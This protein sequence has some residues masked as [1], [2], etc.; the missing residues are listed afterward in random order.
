[1]EY[2][3]KTTTHGRAVMAAC[4]ALER[5][6][7][8][9]RVAF[10]SGMVDKETNLADMH[11]LITYVSDGAVAE[12]RHKDD[13][14]YI[15]IQF[16]NSQHKEVK[17]FLLSEF[18]IYVEDP[19]TGEDT[20]LLYGT[21]GDYR[22]PVP[23]YNPAF[24]PSV[25]NFPLELILSDQINVAVS[26]P[27]GLVTHGEL[28]KLLN[29]IGT[30]RLDITI[31]SSGWVPDTD[32][33]GAYGL[34]VDIANMKI[35]EKMIPVLS[36][37]PASMGAAIACKLC[38]AARTLDGILRVYAAT[39]PTTPIGASLIL[40]DTAY[41]TNGT[42]SG[43]AVKVQEDI[44]I[45]NTGWATDAETGC[46][47]LDIAWPEAT[48][49]T[50]PSVTVLPD[51]LETATACG[52]SPVC[53]TIEGAVRVYAKTVPAAEIKASV[54]L[55]DVSPYANGGGTTQLN[56]GTFPLATAERAG[57]VKPGSGLNIEP[58]GTLSVNTAT[59]EDV[60]NL[61]NGSNALKGVE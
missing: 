1:M 14:L 29:G 12:R 18:I 6:F 43:S 3:Y 57:A 52:F 60:A 33:G 2:S 36:V 50:I 61:F 46:L 27:A 9:T 58:D 10:G 56:G 4:M 49:K 25:F 59:S 38:P 35:T 23:G 20:D 8:I 34:F 11:Q 54:A 16:A 22:Q 45:K 31:P 40:L 19:E 17:T 28:L 41:Q 53:Q 13:R 39:M 47:R 48:R 5:P 51:S 37:T 21:M 44:S 55:L 26:A 24:P 42:I 7:H 30:N 15:T 32:T